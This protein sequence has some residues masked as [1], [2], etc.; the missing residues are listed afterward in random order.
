LISK[1]FNT[2]NKDLLLFVSKVLVLKG[3][4][5]LSRL[6]EPAYTPRN[7]RIAIIIVVSYIRIYSKL[8]S[9]NYSNYNVNPL[10][11]SVYVV[12]FIIVIII[13]NA[14]FRVGRALQWDLG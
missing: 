8:P 4:S 3:E 12:Y 6:S 9:L 11:F 13:G 1:V 7:D 10:R 5:F 2:L 14:C